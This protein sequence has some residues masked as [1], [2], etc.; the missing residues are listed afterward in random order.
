MAAD[1]R[2]QLTLLELL[3]PDQLLVVWGDGH[4]S[5]YPYLELRKR[6]SCA[7]CVDEWTGEPLLDPSKVNPGVTVREWKP[8]GRYG[9]QFTFSDGHGTGIYTLDRLR[10]LCPCPECAA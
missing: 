5:L 3:A 4:E 2:N 10:G 7:K 6:C 9:V 8:T 1:P